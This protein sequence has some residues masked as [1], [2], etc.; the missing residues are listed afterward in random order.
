[1]HRKYDDS[2]AC[3][4]YH[5]FHLPSVVSNILIPILLPADNAYGMRRIHRKTTPFADIWLYVV[6]IMFALLSA[7]WAID[8]YTLWEG[9]D[10]SL[11]I[12]DTFGSTPEV[13]TVSSATLSQPPRTIR[14]IIILLIVRHAPLCRRLN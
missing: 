1:M 2:R 5:E 9:T 8:V 14:L 3:G 10:V 13:T 6:L 4:S 12:I 11:R 7:Y